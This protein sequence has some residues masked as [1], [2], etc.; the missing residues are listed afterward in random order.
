MTVPVKYR[1]K[2]TL[3]ERII[4]VFKET[5]DGLLIVPLPDIVD[6]AGTL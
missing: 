5:D 1:R 6:S 4:L 2:Y 3:R